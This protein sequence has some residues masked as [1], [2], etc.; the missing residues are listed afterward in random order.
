MVVTEH[1]H[2]GIT[3]HGYSLARGPSLSCHD[4]TRAK[5]QDVFA[6]PYKVCLK[7]YRKT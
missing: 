7:S 3:E 1:G 5:E 6:L 2:N 4:L